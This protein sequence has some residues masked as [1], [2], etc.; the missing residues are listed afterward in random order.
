MSWSDRPVV[1]IRGVLTRRALIMATLAVTIAGCGFHPLYAPSGPHDWDP[2]LASIS[3]APIRDRPG[4]ILEQALRENLNPGDMSVKPRWRLS[5]EL[6]VQRADFGIQRNATATTSEVVISATYRLVDLDDKG[7]KQ[8]YTNISRATG[9]FDQLSDAY[10]TQVAADNARDRALQQVAD[11][12]VIRLALFV[13]AQRTKA[14][15]P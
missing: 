3:V 13:R 5:T 11:D 4:Q 12:M 9:D 1:L 14:P 2:A 7:N 8:V 15:T 10:A 6:T